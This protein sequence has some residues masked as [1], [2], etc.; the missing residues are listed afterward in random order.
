MG[1]EYE[2]IVNPFLAILLTFFVITSYQ[3]KI[4]ENERVFLF[5]R[6]DEGIYPLEKKRKEMVFLLKHGSQTPENLSW[7]L[8]EA[9]LIE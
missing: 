3:Y 2:R 8:K 7:Q 4:W 9:W 1:Y 5:L 6:K